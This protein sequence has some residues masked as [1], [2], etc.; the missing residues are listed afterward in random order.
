MPGLS[1]LKHV[2]FY[3]EAS[4]EDSSE[5][6]IQVFRGAIAEYDPLCGG[7]FELA[8]GE[9]CLWI[10]SSSTKEDSDSVILSPSVKAGLQ[11][12]KWYQ[13]ECLALI[14]TT[15]VVVVKSEGMVQVGSVQV[16]SE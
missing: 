1:G 9:P 10:P 15:L 7:K 11:K 4:L 8:H 2:Y 12:T 14:G 16:G 5:N 3:D 13:K 6:S